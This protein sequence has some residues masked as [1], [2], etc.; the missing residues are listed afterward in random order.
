MSENPKPDDNK[1]EPGDLRGQLFKRLAV[2]GALVAIL[3]G[4]LAVFDRLVTTPEESDEPV[5][6][7][8]VPVQP[9]KMLTQPV[10]PAP[11]L[12]EPEVQAVQ[13]SPPPPPQIE[14]QPV[15][16]PVDEKPKASPENHPVN[17]APVPKVA[18]NRPAKVITPT[19]KAVP[20]VIAE[21]TAPPVIA[22]EAVVSSPAPI[23]STAPA[24]RAS[25]PTASPV[26]RL[27]SGFVVQAGVFSSAQRAEELQA[28]LQLS[29]VPATLEARVQVG[30]FKTRQEAEAAQEKLKK[31]GIES[32]LVPPKGARN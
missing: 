19:E 13:P 2:A 26:R 17:N 9:K 20:P 16:Q 7:K 6:S 30:P 8:P 29:G 28:Q 4:I 32:L 12:P 24:V 11:A 5:F 31:M 21:A 22:P 15:A 14:E 3:L 23:A 27:F 10:T 25:E 18:A 1:A